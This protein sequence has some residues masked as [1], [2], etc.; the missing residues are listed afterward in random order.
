[1]NESPAPLIQPPFFVRLL[2][3]VP[4]SKQLP[5]GVMIAGFVVWQVNGLVLLVYALISNRLL[6]FINV[7]GQI[8]VGLGVMGCCQIIGIILVKYLHLWRY[9]AEDSK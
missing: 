5:Q 8:L 3:G 7:G 9:P 1:M 6:P 4:Q 2:C